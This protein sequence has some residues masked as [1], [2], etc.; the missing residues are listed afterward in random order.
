MFK[1]KHDGNVY[2][3]VNVFVSKCDWGIYDNKDVYRPLDTWFLLAIDTEFVWVD[4]S[5]CRPL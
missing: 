5:D 2:E 1:V 3:V 4:A